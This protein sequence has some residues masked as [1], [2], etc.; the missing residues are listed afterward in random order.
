MTRAGIAALV[1]VLIA[2]GAIIWYSRSR[3]TQELLLAATRGDTDTVRAL[4]DRGVDVNARDQHGKT[5]LFW[6][7]MSGSLDVVNLLLER[8]ADV[9]LA[10]K[11]GVTPLMV[12]ANPRQRAQTAVLLAL[13]EKGANINAKDVNGRTPLMYALSDNEVEVA[14]VLIEHGADVNAT[15]KFGPVLSPVGPG[16]RRSEIG[17][18]Q[19]AGTSATCTQI[20]FHPHR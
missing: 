10:D 20:A 6:A 1:V 7:S 9:N 19:I 11:F 18:N 8:G 14:K 16:I 3:S 17:V 12:S 15:N 2:A 13:L 4:L 5:A